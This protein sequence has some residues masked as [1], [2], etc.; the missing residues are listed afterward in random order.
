MNTYQIPYYGNGLKFHSIRCIGFV[1]YLWT[2]T[3]S[4]NSVV[5]FSVAQ[6]SSGIK[7]KLTSLLNNER[8]IMYNMTSTFRE[9]IS[10]LI[11]RV[12]VDLIAEPDFINLLIRMLMDPESIKVTF[13]RSNWKYWRLAASLLRNMDY[14]F[15]ASGIV[16]LFC[17][18]IFCVIIYQNFLFSGIWEKLLVKFEYFE[19]K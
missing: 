8:G 1:W 7:L 4:I 16:L 11:V 5:L 3:I 19:F 2:M 15:G 10:M 13:F 6:S 9:I 18:I 14:S 17:V 12:G